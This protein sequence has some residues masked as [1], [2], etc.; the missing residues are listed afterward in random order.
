MIENILWLALGLLIAAS[1]IPTEK[2]LK[3]T[4]AGA[5]WMFFSVHW[6]L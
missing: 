4:I 6:A 1:L 3:F 2:K 5:G